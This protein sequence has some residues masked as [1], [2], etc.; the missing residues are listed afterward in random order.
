MKSYIAIAS[1]LAFA[2][3]Q[4]HVANAEDIDALELDLDH[5]S[6]QVTELDEDVTG[7]KM[8]IGESQSDSLQ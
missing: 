2:F 3:G 7:L 4:Q 8:Y 6:Q 5:L 1:I